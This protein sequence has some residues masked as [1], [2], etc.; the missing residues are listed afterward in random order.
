MSL[1]IALVFDL[2]LV[3][4]GRILMPWSRAAGVRAQSGDPTDAD[5]DA[6]SASI[7]RVLAPPGAG[8]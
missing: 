2:I 6:D 4:T 8:V 1:L 7:R 3:A 5:T